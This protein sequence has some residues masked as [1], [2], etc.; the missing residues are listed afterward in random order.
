MSATPTPRRA[1]TT[2]ALQPDTDVTLTQVPLHHVF[3]RKH[4]WRFRGCLNRELALSFQPFAFVDTAVSLHLF[5]LDPIHG[6]FGSWLRDKLRDR[7]LLGR[8]GL[9]VYHA[10]RC[11]ARFFPAVIFWTW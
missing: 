11:F 7:G 9:D 4:L 3:G 10:L 2:R 8:D 1:R 6:V 5:F